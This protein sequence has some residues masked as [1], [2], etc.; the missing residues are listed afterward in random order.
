MG[1]PIREARSEFDG[2]FE[3]AFAHHP[4][5]VTHLV[6]NHDETAAVIRDPRVAHVVFTGS[7]PG[8]RQIQN[9]IGRRFIGAG[10]EL[11][12]KDPAYGAADADLDFT[13][14]V[15]SRGLCTMRGSPVA[16]RSG[17][18]CTVT[19][20]RPLWPGRPKP[21]LPTGP[22]I[23]WIRP[24][25]WGRWPSVGPW[26]DSCYGLPASVWTRR[27]ERAEWMAARLGAGTVYQNRCDYLDP[28]LPWAGVKDSGRGASLSR[29]GF[30]Q[31]TRTKSLNFRE[32][33]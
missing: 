30:Y 23:L 33:D 11:G 1:K 2:F 3:Q 10:L 18:T 24:P 8:G 28:G 9:A 27:R 20:T 22:A 17:F 26:I 32:S 14:P 12:G 25:P 4:G 16:G 5:L 19:A 13:C 21:W 15:W 6:L 7:V 31:L 29:C